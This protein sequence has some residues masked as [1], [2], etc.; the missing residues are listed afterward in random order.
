M[1]AIRVLVADDQRVVRDGLTMLLDLLPDIEVVGAAADGRE[2]VDSALRLR[3]DVVLMDLRMPRCDG[4]E[5]TRLLHEQSPQ[6][7]VIVLT[8]YADDRSVLDA[9]RA[10]ARGYLTKDSGADQIH[11]A[12]RHVTSGQAVIDP[13]VAHHLLDEIT[14]HPPRPAHVV[15]PAPDGLTPREVDVLTLIATGLTNGEVAARLFVSE[16]TVKSHLNHLL[17]K[18]GARD[19]AQ[20]VTYAYRNGLVPPES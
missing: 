17:A 9:L 5:A 18:I 11:H 6:I 15:G 14:A 19:R 8:T 13:A 16:A 10:G 7:T 12:L 20:A 3:P 2:A 1:N 4:V